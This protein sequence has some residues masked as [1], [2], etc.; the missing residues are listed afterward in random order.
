M[1]DLCVIL[2]TCSGVEEAKKLARMALESRFV[3][4]VNV[5]PEITSM[6]WWDDNIQEDNEC[7]LVFKTQKNHAEKLYDV[8]RSEHSYDTIEWVVLDVERASDEYADWMRSAIR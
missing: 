7:Q 3:A 6:Y 2:C 5:I 4:C 1:T 8:I